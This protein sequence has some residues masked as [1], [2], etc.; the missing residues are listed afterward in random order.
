MPP[1]SRPRPVV[2][3]VLDG[4][5]CRSDPADNAIRDAQTPNW[6]RFML[7]SPHARLEASEL[8]YRVHFTVSGRSDLFS[9]GTVLYAMCTGHSP[10]RASGTQ[11]LIRCYIEAKS[12][13]NL[14]KLQTA[15]REVLA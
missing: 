8:G 15:R 4:W 11:P 7:E 10:F 14:K 2:L 5:G 1:S 12:K 9:L 6:D 3:C 13:A